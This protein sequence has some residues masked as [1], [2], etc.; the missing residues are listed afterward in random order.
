MQCVSCQFHNMPG[1][2][3]CGRCGSSLTLA[4]DIDINPPRASTRSRAARRLF[5]FPLARSWF[6]FKHRAAGVG[7][8]VGRGVKQELDID[9]PDHHV[10]LFA[11][12]PGLAQVASG[13]RFRGKIFLWLYFALLVC[14][15][16]CFGTTLG[17]V[18]LGFAFA[19]HVSSVIDL[20]GGRGLLAQR[21]AI[22][23]MTM[24]LMVVVIY[25]P[26]VWFADRVAHAIV[27]NQDMGSFR[28]GDVVL[29]NR[30]ARPKPGQLVL[31]L[32]GTELGREGGLQNGRHVIFEIPAGDRVGRVI[33]GPGQELTWDG[34]ELRVD[35]EALDL[36][37]HQF[38]RR[39]LPKKSPF[40]VPDGQWLVQ[41]AGVS[42]IDANV[43][44]ELWRA[45]SLARDE[46]IRGRIY[47]LYQPLGRRSLL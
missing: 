35:G 23:L 33:A 47:M 2:A 43:Q 1:L 38:S 11:I 26:L 44:P 10:L 30:W 14:G 28:R 8:A 27:L 39:G 37:A 15:V 46:D 5:A 12:I 40:R 22:A 16:F 13:H 9:W 36:S 20:L 42:D 32:M 3:V 17:S 34:T 25:L 6:S 21:V 31:F 45:T 24:C 19:V 18:L 29:V 4:A 41:P 7:K